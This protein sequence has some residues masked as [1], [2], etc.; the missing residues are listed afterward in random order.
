MPWFGQE[1]LIAAERKGPLTEPAYLAARA[2]CI[3]LARTEGLDATIAKHS[4]DAIV[5]PSN[6]PAWLTDHLNGDHFVGGDTSFAAVAGYPALTV[7]MGLV[8]ELPVGLTFTG[9]AW[10]E[11]ALLKYGHAFEQ[12]TKARRGPKYFVTLEV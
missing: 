2:K 12:Q 11:A 9:R 10:S 7:P 4:L 8:H 5:F 1:T 3:R 6:S